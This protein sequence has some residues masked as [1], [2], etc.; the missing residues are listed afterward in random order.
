MK[1]LLLIPIAFILLAFITFSCKK[2]NNQD[3]I[4]VDM[5]KTETLLLK[6][7]QAA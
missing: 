3:A 7:Y 1:N 2:D 4:K 5:A 6:N